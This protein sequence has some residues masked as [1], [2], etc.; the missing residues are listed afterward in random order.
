MRSK[1]IKHPWPEDPS[2]FEPTRLTTKQLSL[3][4]QGGGGEEGRTAA[5]RKGKSAERKAAKS[6]ASSKR[7]KKRR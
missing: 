1:Y 7:G 6:S 3:Q 5:D 4:A 2:T